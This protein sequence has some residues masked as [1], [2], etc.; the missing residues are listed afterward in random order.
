[1]ACS[2]NLTR[3]DLGPQ[4]W[5]QLSAILPLLLQQPSTYKPAVQLMMQFEV[6]GMER[7]TV[8]HLH[9]HSMETA[10]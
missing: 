3:E 5:Q 1:M 4:G 9:Q 6:C 10:C 8:H 7:T 2:F